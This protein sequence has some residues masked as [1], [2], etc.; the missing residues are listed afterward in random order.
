MYIRLS[1]RI[2]RNTY[3]LNK[4]KNNTPKKRQF[5]QKEKLKKSKKEKIYSNL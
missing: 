2:Y 5:I 1:K 3:N 4:N